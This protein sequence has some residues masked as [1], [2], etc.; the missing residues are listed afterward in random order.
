M[1]IFQRVY[2][3][4]MLILV[5]FTIISLW[6]DDPYYSTINLV[7]W[8]V[9]VID[10][11]VRLFH[12]ENK[13][14][15]LKKNPLLVIAIIPF[16]QF[17]QVARIVRVIYLFRIKT[18]TKYYIQPF[19][20]KLSYQSK[21]L[22]FLTLFGLLSLEAALIYFL[23]ESAGSL[24]Q[25]FYYVFGHMMFFGHELFVIEH[26]VTIWLLSF[27]SIIGIALHGLA[28][29]WIFTSVETFFKK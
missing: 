5:L 3:G 8:F 7:V 21:V 16:D 2:E 29:Q 28:I 13:W 25:S 6:N 27:T 24:W 26:T 4:L 17:F 14:E 12:S 19:I 23:E 20:E 15:F 22:I 1:K 11:F 9:F 10:F 18:I